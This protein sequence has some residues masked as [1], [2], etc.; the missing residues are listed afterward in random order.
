MLLARAE[1]FLR[2]YD[3]AGSLEALTE[4]EASYLVK[5]RSL[6][7]I[8]AKAI[9]EGIQGIGQV[10][11]QGL[12]DQ[13]TIADED[14]EISDTEK[15]KFSPK[16]KKPGQMELPIF[17]GQ[18]FELDFGERG[19]TVQYEKPA[20]PPEPVAPKVPK[21]KK[22]KRDLDN[23]QARAQKVRMVTTGWLGSSGRL[24]RDL[25]ETASLASTI[26][27]STQELIYLIT[28]DKNGLI[29]EIHKYSKGLQGLVPCLTGRVGQ[30][31]QKK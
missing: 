30:P 12:W 5:F 15:V 31:Q 14:L 19:I 11:Q 17:K 3:I 28:T 29:L 27:K 9:K 20:E 6:D 4:R 1:P 24:V 26:Q 22:V 25:D 18:Q 2:D 23:I 13:G 21:K 8:R 16:F 10:F 7:G